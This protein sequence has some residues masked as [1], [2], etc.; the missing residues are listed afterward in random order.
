MPTAIHSFS[1]EE[2]MAYLDGELS[3]V[4]ALAAA[5]HLE[6]CRD[7]QRLAADFRN[8]SQRLEDWKI[9]PIKSLPP[10]SLK[11]EKNGCSFFWKHRLTLSASVM[12]ILIFSAAVF[13]QFNSVTSFKE[14]ARMS[15]PSQDARWSRAQMSYSANRETTLPQR[16]RGVVGG[17]GL[18]DD[19]QASNFL[20]PAPL[21]SPFEGAIPTSPMIVRTAQLIITSKNFDQS[22]AEVESIARAHQGYISELQLN[23]PSGSARTLTVTLRAPAPQLPGVLRDLRLLGSVLEESQSGEDVT[24]RYVDLNARLA[25]LR[26]TEQRLLQI[27]RERTGRLADVL[28]VEESVDRTRGEIE[29]AEAEQKLFSTQIE[30]ATVKFKISEE[31]KAQLETPEASFSTR[32]RNAAVAGYRN[33]V[34]FVMAIFEFLLSA[35]PVLLLIAASCFFPARWLWRRYQ[36]GFWPFVHS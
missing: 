33:V 7:C 11:E 12:A 8:I 25:N 16:T 6:Q 34:D 3:P 26:T 1:Q 18:R 10:R 14:T 21:Q 5:E 4:R 29:S 27:L 2:M 36:Q 19:G 28:Q 20:G 22:R 23:A 32:L 15:A 30:F 35:G 31:Y 13:R 9:E 24:A 17:T